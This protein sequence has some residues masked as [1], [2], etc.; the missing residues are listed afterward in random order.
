MIDLKYQ[1]QY[2]W[3]KDG[4]KDRNSTEASSRIYIRKL[5]GLFIFRFLRP[6]RA[7][8]VQKSRSHTLV[9]VSPQ[10]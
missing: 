3:N 2:N 7:R 10:F 8:R 4:N 9:S 5:K 6:S 1:L